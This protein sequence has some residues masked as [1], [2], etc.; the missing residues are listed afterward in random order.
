FQ[1]LNLTCG[2]NLRLSA[3]SEN[4]VPP[5][6]PAPYGWFARPN[7]GD[8]TFP[9]IVPGLSRFTMLRIAIETLRTYRWPVEE[10]PGAPPV[11]NGPVGGRRPLDAGAA[12]SPARANADVLA[13]R[14]RV[15]MEPTN[16]P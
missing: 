3:D 7:R 2:S 9:M 10:P 15:R 6:D 8:V 11:P 13:T 12:V 1:N 16:V 4:P 5:S 14:Q